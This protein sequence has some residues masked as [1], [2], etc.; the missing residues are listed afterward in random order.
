ML[1]PDSAA[2]RETMS[3]KPLNYERV[4]RQMAS[5]DIELG[6]AEV[7]GV[8]CGLACAGHG[9]VKGAWFGEL[10]LGGN[11]GD[12]LVQECRDSMERLY[13]GTMDA[14][15]GPGLGFA[16]FLPED[17]KPIRI[18]ARAVSDW[19]QGF[20]YGAGLAGLAPES[21]LSSETQEALKDFA[22]ITRMDTDALDDS[23]E[24]EDALTEV[25]EFLWVAAMLVHSELVKDPT[26]RS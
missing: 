24:D 4:E 20:L 23:E 11:D 12:L 2:G 13:T 1:D 14:I 25:I 17:E 9:D 21:Q 15:H 5:A 7:H 8:L 19:C 26:E 10:F 3:E 6:A 22:E 16:P 18:R